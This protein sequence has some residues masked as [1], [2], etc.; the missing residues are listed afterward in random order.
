MTTRIL[1][2]DDHP[3]FRKG[4]CLLLEQEKTLEIIGEA[5]DGQESIEMVRKEQPDLVVMDI[6]MPKLNGMEA[7]RKILSEFP[8]IKI[9]ALS[10]HSGKRF[11]KKM[12]GAGA[13]GYILKESVPEELVNGILKV[14][15]GDIYLS[16]TITGVLVSDYRKIIN[17]PPGFSEAKTL[18]PSENKIIKLISEG[19]S[20]PQIVEIIGINIEAL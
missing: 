15:Q 1:L 3:I 20:I 19:K 9:V 13:V 14:V 12:L 17:N 2:V 5:G 4:L 16:D 8:D 7:T 18:S 11:V 6:T 10:I